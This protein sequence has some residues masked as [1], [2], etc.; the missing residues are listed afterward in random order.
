[1]DGVP[2]VGTNKHL[3]EWGVLDQLIISTNLL[4]KTAGAHIFA[5]EFLLLED[6]RW[7][8]KKPFRTYNG[9]VYQG[10]YSDHLPVWLDFSF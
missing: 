5:P 2:G 3:S 1:M 8:G 6:E 4:S 9:M 7:L 10:G